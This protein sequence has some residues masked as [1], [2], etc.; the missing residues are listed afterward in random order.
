MKVF[1]LMKT[2][3]ITKVCYCDICKKEQLHNEVL[4][5]I[6]ECDVCKEINVKYSNLENIEDIDTIVI[7]DDDISLVDAGFIPRHVRDRL[8]RESEYFP[9]G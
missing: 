4:D 3:K 2:V 1:G 9:E 5:Q 7:C 6:W 8:I